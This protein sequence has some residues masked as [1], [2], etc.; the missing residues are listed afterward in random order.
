MRR[1][2]PIPR[3]GIGEHRALDHGHGIGGTSELGS[4][5]SWELDVARDDYGAN[6]HYVGNSAQ[7]ML[8]ITVSAATSESSVSI[9]PG[10]MMIAPAT[11]SLA[12]ASAYPVPP[13]TQ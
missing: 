8:P 1:H 7:V 11:S 6:G 9:C 5:G 12:Y 3:T 4:S 13:V 2:R 10:G